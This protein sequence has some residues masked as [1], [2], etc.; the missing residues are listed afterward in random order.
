[1]ASAADRN[2]RLVNENQHRTEAAPVNWSCTNNPPNQENVTV[3]LSSLGADPLLS[4]H[5]YHVGDDQR[6]AQA[7]CYYDAYVRSKIIST[8]I[9]GVLPA[10]AK[11]WMQRVQDNHAL[12]QIHFEHY[13]PCLTAY[14]TKGHQISDLASFPTVGWCETPV[15][16]QGGGFPS[17][18]NYSPADV[19]GWFKTELGSTAVSTRLRQNGLLYRPNTGT[20]AEKRK[21]YWLAS[22][23]GGATFE[24]T[25]KRLMGYGLMGA[26]AAGD[27]RLDIDA[28]LRTLRA[29]NVNFTRIWATEQW[30]NL[31]DLD[32]QGVIPFQGGPFQLDQQSYD[33]RFDSEPFFK[34]L[35][36][37]VQAAA[38]RGIVIQFTL[39]DK[40]GIICADERGGYLESPYRNA[41]NAIAQQYMED[42][43]C[44][45]G[46]AGGLVETPDAP[47]CRP[48]DLFIDPSH[49][50][51][52][53]HRRFMSRV[54]EE[55]GGIGNVIFEIINEAF[56]PFVE[57]G[58]D[59]DGDWAPFGSPHPYPNEVWQRRMLEEMRL[60]LPMESTATAN[61][62]VR[63]AF[64]D[65]AEGTVI[66]GK[67]SDIQNAPWLT[68]WSHGAKVKVSATE[69]TSDGSFPP[70]RRMGYATS[71]ATGPDMAA[72]ISIGTAALWTKLQVRADLTCAAGRMSLG[73]NHSLGGNS[74]FAFL[75]CGDTSFDPP[76]IPSLSLY[77]KVGS[78]TN[79]LETALF[80]DPNLPHHVR[81]EVIIDPSDNE[82]K[83]SIYLDGT[84][85]IKQVTLADSS[86][87]TSAWFWGSNCYGNPTC[88]YPEGT[89]K[90]DNFEVARFCDDE[91]RGCQP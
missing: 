54:G 91:Y 34:R 35:R 86:E 13:E 84:R 36:K 76:L 89:G 26:L 24:N 70:V 57:N 42:D 50:I 15:A 73:F 2:Q 6:E 80:P 47:P 79:L 52:W 63:D 65:N 45:C 82:R 49:E 90:V 31:A 66:S 16:Q 67:A 51:A 39:F 74:V 28:Y 48:L 81:L 62:V 23:D 53:V 77:E 3:P 1:M 22:I 85:Q 55:V 19:L 25:P 40:H 20:D 7:R 56:A 27:D 38:D 68:G 46:G 12:G 9:G 10:T 88:V 58:V 14:G 64:N 72:S 30:T 5:A 75:D 8:D 21:L 11:T 17:N 32:H 29:H 43:A 83:A 71:N 4:A 33:L 41:N 69:G 18:W 60:S 59:K 44:T 78:S 61:H 37:L 87:F